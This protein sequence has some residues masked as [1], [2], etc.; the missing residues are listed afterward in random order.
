MADPVLGLDLGGAHLKAALARD[1]RVLAV[2][3]VPCRLWEGL[4]R[5]GPAF[6]AAL[7][8]LPQPGRV[9]LTMTGELA[10]LFAD[11]A[12]GVRALVAAV[13][14]RFADTPLL[15]WAGREGFLDATAAAAKPASVASANWLAT[16]TLAAR[17]LGTV[18]CSTSA[19]R[20]PTS[21][22]CSAGRSGSRATAM[23]SGWLRAS[24]STRASPARR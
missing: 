20:P 9:A 3:Q 12:S 8:G 10:D 13:E 2:R 24:W 18:C 21:C 14:M 22:R 23:P 1:G 4:E 6:A 11:R 16:A 5:L 17:R 15:V 19:A 7:A